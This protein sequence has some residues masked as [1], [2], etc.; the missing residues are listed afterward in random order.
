MHSGGELQ[1]LILGRPSY[2]FLQIRVTQDYKN[3]GVE[4]QEWREGV[5]GKAYC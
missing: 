1:R 2:F 3:R 5:E 4:W